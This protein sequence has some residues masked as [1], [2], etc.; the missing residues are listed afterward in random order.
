MR[1]GELVIGGVAI[2]LA[3]FVFILTLGFPQLPDGHP[4]PGL[5][6]QLLAIILAIMGLVLIGQNL[7]KRD[8]S[9]GGEEKAEGRE[10]WVN[11]LWV[12]GVILC[13]MFISEI[14]GFMITAVVIS[15]VLM[16]RLGAARLKGFVASMAAVLFVYWLFSQVLLVPL[17][18]GVMGY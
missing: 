1:I 16:L 2:A 10:E 17:P 15:W 6:P 8:L 12:I 14:A 4:G 11:I 3:V 18:L 13:Y 5:F 9:P 7:S